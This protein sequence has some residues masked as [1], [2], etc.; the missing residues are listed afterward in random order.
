MNIKENVRDKTE[1]LFYL[2][3]FRPRTRKSHN[4]TKLYQITLR[5]ISDP[6]LKSWLEKAWVFH[7]NLENGHN[8]RLV[9]KD[10]YVTIATRMLFQL[11][12]EKLDTVIARYELI[13]SWDI[14]NLVAKYENK[15]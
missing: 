12:E 9:K 8:L 2:F 1:I 13:S 7:I 10:S 15:K 4:T 3:I 14:L 6:E 11:L 5:I